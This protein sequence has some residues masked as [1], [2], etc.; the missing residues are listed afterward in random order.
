MNDKEIARHVG[1]GY[2][3][4]TYRDDETDTEV[5][6]VDIA[7]EKIALITFRGTEVTE[8]NFSWKDVFTDLK[9]Y[10][11]YSKHLNCW[12]HAGFRKAAR[13]V[14]AYVWKEIRKYKE[15]GY[16]VI[17]AGHSL[18][19]ALAVLSAAY[20]KQVGCPVD[21]LTTFG[22]P[23]VGYKG[24]R[25]WVKDIPG[26]RYINGAD[27]VP[28]IPP[29]TYSGKLILWYSHDRDGTQLGDRGIPV[30]WDW[31]DHAIE[32]YITGVPG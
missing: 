6:S 15:E 8:G 19:G 17:L 26:H 23:R 11:S 18:G 30:L 20:S 28:T 1:L 32:K 12:T 4:H 9:A 10:P 29:A 3:S 27:P 24:L 31:T 16:F 2:H 5:Y 21:R 22:A 13:S 25:G 14:W 7:A